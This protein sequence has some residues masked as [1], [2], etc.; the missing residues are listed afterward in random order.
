MAAWP[1]LPFQEARGGGRLARPSPRA[2]RRCVDWARCG[3]ERDS[4]GKSA[5]TGEWSLDTCCWTWSGFRSRSSAPPPPPPPHSHPPTLT[6]MTPPP[7]QVAISH[8]PPGSGCICA[9]ARPSRGTGGKPRFAAAE[10]PSLATGSAV[11]A[12]RLTGTALERRFGR[13]RGPGGGRRARRVASLPV[14]HSRNRDSE[15]NFAH[16][17]SKLCTMTTAHLR[18]ARILGRIR[19]R[20][21]CSALVQPRPCACRRHCGWLRGAPGP[22]SRLLGAA[23]GGKQLPG[24]LPLAWPLRRSSPRPARAALGGIGGPCWRRPSGCL[25]PR[26]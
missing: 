24:A 12:T 15:N 8:T 1:W 4:E 2:P 17:R 13:A 21:P 6:S 10:S 16:A 25:L 20:R 19:A 5:A 11:G 22:G 7:P 26:W 18:T 9:A 23:R 3:H 14:P